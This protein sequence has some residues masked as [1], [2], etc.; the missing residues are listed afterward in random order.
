MYQLLELSKQQYQMHTDTM[1]LPP[2]DIIKFN[3]EPVRYWQFMRLFTTVVDK[4]TVPAAEKLTRFLQYTVDRARDAISHCI[5]NPD[6][7]VGYSEAMAILKRRFGNPYT[8]AQAW[9]GRVLNYKDI[10]GGKQLQAF[11]DTLR[12]CRDTLRAMKCADELDAGR[13]LLKIVQ[14]LP[15]D[16]RKRWLTRNCEITQSGHLPKLDD[17]L[18]LVEVE[19]AKRMDPIF[20]GLLGQDSSPGSGSS[21]NFNN[22]GKPKKMQSF[23]AKSANGSVAATP[24]KSSAS[25]GFKCPKCND[26]HFLNQC[27]AFR[28]MSVPAHLAFVQQRKLCLN[29]FMKGHDRSECTRRWVC[30]VPG[31]AQRHNS[32]LHSAI[33]TSSNNDDNQQT[34]QQPSETAKKEPAEPVFQTAATK[35]SSRQSS[36]KI[37][38]PIVP[39]RVSKPDTND[40]MV[41]LALLDSGSN[42]SFCSHK[43]IDTLNLNTRQTSIRL[44]TMET[45]NIE[46]KTVNVDLQVS[47]LRQWH[48]YKIKGILGRDR[49]NISLES[50]VTRD[51]VS[52]WDHL[53]D[54]VEE[55]PQIDLAE[56]VHLLTGLDQ[57][58]IL[59]PREW[60]QG[61][62][63]QLYSVLTNLGWTLNGPINTPYMSNTPTVSVNF[64]RTN[65]A[66]DDTDLHQIVERFWKIEDPSHLSNDTLSVNDKIVMDLWNKHS[67]K[68]GGHYM[69][70][71]PFKERPPPLPPNYQMAKHWLDLLGKRLG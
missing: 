51:E 68:E 26:K 10:R 59:A 67:T 54:I 42:G 32:W 3:G 23:A 29:C 60:H 49:L 34:T 64:L 47:D 71:I 30:K 2:T 57:P 62:P 53:S 21:P 20:G 5:Y 9:I 1:R 14:K 7:D 12:S 35:R 40:S 38:L 28:S 55:F 37:S 22:N 66:E 63:G 13:S 6:P 8:V 27:P 48:S 24:S 65:A 69:L 50:L 61:K 15:H 19:A 52:S 4:E 58:D 56:E 11:A 39:V 46:I 41:V 31:C 16:L 45:K 33:A 70:P 25:S 17:V 18:D 44:T 43:L 36:W